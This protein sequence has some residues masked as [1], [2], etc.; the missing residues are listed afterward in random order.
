[1]NLEVAIYVNVVHKSFEQKS[2]Y[3]AEERKVKKPH[4]ICRTASY[5]CLVI[6]AGLQLKRAS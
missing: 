6:T 2:M 3:S 1:M 4:Y 5:N